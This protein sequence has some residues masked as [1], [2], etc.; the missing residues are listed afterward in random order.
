ML[1]W[2]CICSG[3]AG[4]ELTCILAGNGGSGSG[5]SASLVTNIHVQAS[6]PPNPIVVQRK[7]QAST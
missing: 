5:L 2:Y 3:E 6:A 4:P 1:S 7:T